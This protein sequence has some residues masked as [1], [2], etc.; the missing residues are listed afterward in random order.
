VKDSIH[1]SGLLGG[2]GT[3]AWGVWGF[4]IFL[5]FCEQW[6]AWVFGSSCCK[7]FPSESDRFI[8][9]IF[10]GLIWLALEKLGM[11]DSSC[12]GMVMDMALAQLG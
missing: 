9:W 12:V 2:G 5:L 10:E 4:R 6:Q 11:S 3:I 8:F 1:R 7:F